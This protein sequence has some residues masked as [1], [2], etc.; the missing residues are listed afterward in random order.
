MASGVFLAAWKYVL[1]SRK[2]RMTPKVFLFEQ[3]EERSSSLSGWRKGMSVSVSGEI[4]SSALILY[5][6][7]CVFDT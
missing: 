7:R 1:D 2:S 3:L 5:L 4:K 6:W